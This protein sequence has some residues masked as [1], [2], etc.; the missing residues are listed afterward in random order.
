MMRT[1]VL[2]GI[3]AAALLAATAPAHADDWRWRHDDWRDHHWHEHWRPA[4]RPWAYAPPP[5]V[6]Y[7]PPPPRYYGPPPAAYYG[8]GAP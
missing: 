1:L 3:G 4:W 6:Y 5:P 2:A 7:A 8:Y